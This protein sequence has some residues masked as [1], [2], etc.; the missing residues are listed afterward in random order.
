MRVSGKV[1]SM[2]I[3]YSKMRGLTA[4]EMISALR[5]DGFVL[6]RRAGSHKQYRHPDGR[7][8]T[9][10]HHRRGDS[11]Q[12]GTLKAMVEQQ[13]RWTEADLKRLGLL[14]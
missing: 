1:R 2:A 4:R 9:V 5:R 12:I 10:A 3:D 8:V 14:R 13:A 6:V 11:F 7:Q